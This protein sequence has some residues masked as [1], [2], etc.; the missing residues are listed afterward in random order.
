[1]E[2]VNIELPWKPITICPIGDLQYGSPGCDVSKVQEYIEDGLRTKAYFLGMGD[3]HDVLSPSNRQKLASAA[4]YD[5]ARDWMD[6]KMMEDIEFLYQEIFKPTKGKWLGMLQGHHWWE[7]DDS[8][9]TD[10]ELCRRL[11]AQFLGDCA[12][13]R[14]NFIKDEKTHLKCDIWCHHGSGAGSTVGA[15]L[16]KMERISG[17]F[18]ADL[19]FTG[20]ANRLGAAQK[21]SLDLA[22]G[23]DGKPLRLVHRDRRLVSTGAF[24]KG[25]EV[26]STAGRTGRA[27]GGYVEKAMMLPTGLGAPMVHVEPVFRIDEEPELKIRVTV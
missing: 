17:S 3:Y 7:F 22:G 9:T 10:T 1:M 12:F 16:N 19:I 24:D 23:M 4:F 14:I 27:A 6:K 26:G 8:S 20:H 18:G 21:S 5:N 13:I 11:G 2:L 15:S 25:Y